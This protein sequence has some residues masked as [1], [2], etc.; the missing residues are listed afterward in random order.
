M[1]PFYFFLSHK[2]RNK[3]LVSLSE[4]GEIRVKGTEINKRASVFQFFKP[5][6]TL[7]LGVMRKTHLGVHEDSNDSILSSSKEALTTSPF[8]VRVKTDG[9]LRNKID[10]VDC[11]I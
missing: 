5:D 7:D 2:Y 9:I 10:K 1:R 4:I 3:R 8:T 6:V 11:F